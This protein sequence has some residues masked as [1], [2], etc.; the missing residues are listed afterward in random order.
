MYRVKLS[1]FEGPL[2]L[3]LFFIRR[4]ELDIYDIPIATITDEFLAYVKIL[5][6]VDLD[7]AGDFV[8]FAALLVNIKTR[9]LLPSKQVDEE[10]EIVDPRTELVEQFCTNY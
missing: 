9:M 3:L 2:D 7:V 5:T 10:G 8:Y 6:E 1:Q 4:D